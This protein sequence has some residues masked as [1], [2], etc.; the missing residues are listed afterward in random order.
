[1]LENC[2]QLG[3]LNYNNQARALQPRDVS[4]VGSELAELCGSCAEQQRLIDELFS[5][6]NPILSQNKNEGIGHPSAPEALLV[7]LAG[8]IRGTRRVFEVNNSRLRDIISNIRL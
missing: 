2:A 8:E 4:E 6:L 3:G 5:V 1:M 7:P